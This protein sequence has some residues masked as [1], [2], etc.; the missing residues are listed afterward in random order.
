MANQLITFIKLFR[1]IPAEDE[2]LIAAVTEQR[3]H[4]ENDYLFTGG[5]MCRE[6]FFVCK[7]V[8]GTMALNEMAKRLLTIL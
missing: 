2:A 5:K 4:E 1:H 6:I 3:F 8:L 7:G